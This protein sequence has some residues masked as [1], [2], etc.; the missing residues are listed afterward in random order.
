MSQFIELSPT[1][2]ILSEVPAQRRLHED[3]R[4]HILQLEAAAQ[5]GRQLTLLQDVEHLLTKTVNVLRE[6]FG[7]YQAHIL[8]VDEATNELVLKEASGP[9]ADLI[10]RLGLRLKPGEG[11]TGWVIESG[12]PKL[13]NDVRQESRYYGV[14]LVPDTRAELA[15]P[16]RL[17]ERIIGVLDVQSEYCGAFYEEDILALQ[18]IGDQVAIALENA[19]LF[20]ETKSQL[21]AMRALHEISLDIVGKLDLAALLNTLL[22]RAARLVQAESAVLATYDENSGL[23]RNIANYQTTRDWTGFT[24]RPGEGIIGVVIQTGEPLIVNDYTKWAHALSVFSQVEQSA[25]LGVP[26]RWHGQII[27]ALLV[28]NR[29]HNHLFTLDDQWALSPFADL[30][31]IALKNA[32]LYAQVKSFS[33]TLEAQVFER[34][35]ELVQARQQLLEKSEQVQW[36][37]SKTVHIQ[38]EERARI[39][40][41]LHD[42]VTQLTIGALYELQAAKADLDAQATEAAREKVDIARDL[43]KQIER[44]LRQAIYDLRPAS[45]DASGLAPALQKYVA[46]F[47]E[48][49]GIQC[50]VQIIGTPVRLPSPIEVVIF[51]LAQEALHNVMSHAHAQHVSISLDFQAMHLYLT[52]SDDGQGFELARAFEPTGHHHVG[53][54]S[55]HE[56]AAVIGGE[57]EVSSQPGQGTRVTLCVACGTGSE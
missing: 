50:N 49:S 33:Q 9:A 42:S 15:V 54:V 57:L 3:A 1:K 44:E 24:R 18:L 4:R 35:Q 29:P 20:Q 10:K 8:L 16:L 17:G 55:M 48:L 5:V 52:V 40:R 22:E 25:T 34:T 47:Q 46:S 41:D 28:L 13:V 23:I 30:A 2:S 43:L 37:L 14:E 36:L 7:Y 19:R 53:L 26:L 51:R 6:T 56:R 32:E 31:A 45:L 39:A 27:G 38:E 11:I 21:A 12:E